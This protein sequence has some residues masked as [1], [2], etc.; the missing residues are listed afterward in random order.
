MAEETTKISQQEIDVC[1]SIPAQLVTRTIITTSGPNARITFLEQHSPETE[2]HARA[3]VIMT[4]PE[5]LNLRDLL[6]RIVKP[7]EDQMAQAN[8]ENPE[9]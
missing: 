5:A 3:S 9:D 7:L 2:P 6:T 1:Y 4:L 8:P